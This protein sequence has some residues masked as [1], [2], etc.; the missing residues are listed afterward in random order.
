MPPIRPKPLSSKFFKGNLIRVSPSGADEIGDQLVFSDDLLDNKN[1]IVGQH[2]GF[3]TRVRMAPGNAPDIFQCVATF[4]L[5]DG[6]VTTRGLLESNLPPA[7]GLKST[8]GI[9]G[10]TGRYDNLRGQVT[11]TVRAPGEQDYDF[12]THG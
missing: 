11:V 12:E 7:V 3:C 6:Q 10:G 8:F 4:K 9:S 5:P 1:N 2:S